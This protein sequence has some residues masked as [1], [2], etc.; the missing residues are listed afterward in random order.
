MF[1]VH[2]PSVAVPQHAGDL[3]EDASS[4]TK[5][6][7]VSTTHQNHLFQLDKVRILSLQTFQA[8]VNAD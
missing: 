8:R 5:H 3:C 7:L 1:H 2:E 6:Q 4:E